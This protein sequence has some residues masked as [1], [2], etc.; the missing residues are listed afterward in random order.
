[1]PPLALHGGSSAHRNSSFV[2]SR[3]KALAT[4]VRERLSA[5]LRVE[6]LSRL[7]LVTIPR[8][9][10]RQPLGVERAAQRIGPAK[11]PA[12]LLRHPAIQVA[13]AG[14][15]ML[16]LA[17]GGQAKPLLRSLMGLLLGHV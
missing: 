12:A 8:Q 17:A 4:G 6:P 11:L 3:L 7:S 13:R 1:M 5:R 10:D 14:L 16:D 9:R 15:A 2:L